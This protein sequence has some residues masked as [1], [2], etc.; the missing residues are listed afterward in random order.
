MGIQ[1]LQASLLRMVQTGVWD[2]MSQVRDRINGCCYFTQ[3]YSGP[4]RGPDVGPG[5]WESLGVCRRSLWPR[6]L[7]SLNK[8]GS[9]SG[10]ASR[11]VRHSS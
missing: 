3:M 5:I 2:S 9:A 7:E 8:E 11:L 6:I 1:T 10:T 4:A